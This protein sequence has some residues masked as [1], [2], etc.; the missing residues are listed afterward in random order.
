MFVANAYRDIGEFNLSAL[1]YKDALAQ[2]AAA[3]S[4]NLD[5]AVNFNNL[6]VLQFL[7]A[8]TAPNRTENLKHYLLAKNYL[9][10]AEN[11][12][13]AELSPC[14]HKTIEANLEHCA[15][16]LKFLD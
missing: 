16:E 6:A 15:T 7:L 10:Q 5:R 13:E 2:P 3:S 1:N 14:L 9:G 12:I 11:L 8:K 4:K